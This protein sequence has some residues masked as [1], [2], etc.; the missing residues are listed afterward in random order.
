MILSATHAIF[1][2]YTSLI[3]KELKNLVIENPM[4]FKFQVKNSSGY[5]NRKN[6]CQFNICNKIA[7]FRHSKL[8]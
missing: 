6:S 5:S 3:F 2:T 4:I 7:V 8:N 1:L